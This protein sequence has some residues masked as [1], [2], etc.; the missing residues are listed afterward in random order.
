MPN[1]T[2]TVYYT[3]KEDQTQQTF[4]FRAQIDKD[5]V[6]VGFF[7]KMPCVHIT[8]NDRTSGVLASAGYFESCAVG[9]MAAKYGTVAMIQLA[10]RLWMDTHPRHTHV[11]FSDESAIPCPSAAHKQENVSLSLHHLI[12]HGKTW[13]DRYFGAQLEDAFAVN[14]YTASQRLVTKPMPD[15]NTFMSTVLVNAYTASQERGIREALTGAATVADGLRA[16]NERFRCNFFMKGVLKRIVA[17]LNIEDVDGFIWFIPKA[18]IQAYDVTYEIVKDGTTGGGCKAGKQIVW[19]AG[20]LPRKLSNYEIRLKASCKR[21]ECIERK[22]A[23]A[24]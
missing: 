2:V 4:R 5:A 14:R 15:V 16:I 21:L 12:T 8:K 20:D 18:T 24:C 19:T 1:A 6:Y 13:Y 17:R 10:L 23:K 3:H 22:A 11:V 7:N 9:G